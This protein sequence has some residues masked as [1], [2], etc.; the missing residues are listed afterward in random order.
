MSQATSFKYVARVRPDSKGRV[1]LGRLGKDISSYRVA[2]DGEGRVLLEPFVEV[3]AREQ[4]LYENPE[5]YSSVR[6]GLAQAGKGETAS[7]GSFARP[8]PKAR[9]P[10]K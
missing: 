7:L 9:K 8:A 4:W 10:R 2:V 5:A 1:T 6:R 3:P